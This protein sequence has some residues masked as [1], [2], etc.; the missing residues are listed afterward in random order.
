MNHQIG[1]ELL[2]DHLN[3]QPRQTRGHEQ[4]QTH[5]WSRQSDSHIDAHDDSEVQRFNTELIKR[6]RQDRTEDENGRYGVKEHAGDQQ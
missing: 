1:H 5:R 6:R 2:G 3:T 4:D